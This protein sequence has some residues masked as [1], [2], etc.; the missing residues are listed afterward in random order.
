MKTR[1]LFYDDVYQK[2][3]EAEVLSCR[4]TEKGYEILLDQTA[5]YPE[6]GG[7]PSDR[8]RLWTQ[9]G[10]SAC[11]VKEVQYDGEEIWHRTDGP[12]WQGSKVRGCIDW[13]RRFDLMQQHSGEHLVSGFIYQLYGYH[14]VG[15]HMGEDVITVDVSGELSREEVDKV[16]QKVNAYIWSNKET[17]V[18]WPSEEER[19]KLSYRSKK[20]LTGEVRL[21]EFPGGDCCACC[22]LHV[23]RAGEIGMV[24]M[25]SL[26]RFRSGVRLEMA[27]G[28]RA[29]AILSGSFRANASVAAALS[30]RSEE[31]AE[32]V[33]RLQEEN[34][35][36]RGQLIQLKNERATFRADQCKNMGNVLVLEAAMETADIRKEADSILETCGGICIVVSGEETSGYKYA[37]GQR[38]GDVRNFV[39]EMNHSLGGRGGGKPFFAQGSFGASKKEIETFF[40]RKEFAVLS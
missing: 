3:F 36:L 7:Q 16:E 39:K 38:D 25:L 26:H 19:D 28:K 18:F 2:E 5:F 6:G 37:I 20:E 27:A 8:G 29:M 34:Y 40:Q 9:D 4:Q 13:D 32:A 22:G 21:V 23:E 33:K 12:L 17:E 15:F 30:V 1:R 14:N 35:G 24:K 10:Q 31:T 11:Q